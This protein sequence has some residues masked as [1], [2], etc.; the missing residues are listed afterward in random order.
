VRDAL[1]AR[2]RLTFAEFMALALYHPDDGYYARVGAGRDYRTSPQISPAFGHLIGRLLARMW[3]ALGCPTPF[4]AVEVGA[5]DGRLRRQVTACWSAGEPALAE[6]ARYVA[7]DR[8]GAPDVV[9]DAAA[10]PLAPF[11]GCVLT[12]ELFDALPV[13]RLVGPRGELWVVERDGQ[14]AFQVGE[15]SDRSLAADLPS[16]PGQIVDVAP[17]ASRVIDEIAGSLARGYALTIDY[18]GSSEELR[19]PYRMAGTLLAYHGGRAHDRVLERPGQQDLTAHV[20][21]DRLQSSGRLRTVLLESQSA[22]LERL[23]LAEWLGRLDPGRLTPADLF[24]AKLRATE[25][26]APGGLGKLR[27]LLQ[28]KGAPDPV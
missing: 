18:G 6:V 1:A 26:V 28:A 8:F 21:F 11:V 2:G 13:H 12:N 20:D 14:L 9:A 19:A 17:A 27:V 4:L 3:R 22:F 7:V 25:L 5:G 10:L 23:G 15:L 24:N 16:R